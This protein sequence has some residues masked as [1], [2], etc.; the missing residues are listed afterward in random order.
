LIH[1]F[2][3]AIFFGVDK[4]K[5]KILKNLLPSYVGSEFRLS[6][7]G[8]VLL[9]Q[10]KI[11]KKNTNFNENTIPYPGIKLVTSGIAFDSL[12]PNYCSIGSVE[13]TL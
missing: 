3:I 12:T 4:R 7:D 2:K 10:K 8:V 1:D 6:V 5:F 13:L 9:N 11:K